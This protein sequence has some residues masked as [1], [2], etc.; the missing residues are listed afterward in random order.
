MLIIYLKKLEKLNEEIKKT[1]Q[2]QNPTNHEGFENHLY[3]ID[4]EKEIAKLLNSVNREEILSYMNLDRNEILDI[5]YGTDI[6]KYTDNIKVDI[7]IIT[8]TQNIG[9]SCKATKLSEVGV[10]EMHGDMFE[11][12]CNIF[13]KNNN[14]K[15]SQ[16]NLNFFKFFDD[17]NCTKKQCEK[18]NL[19]K[20]KD[21]AENIEADWK[22][23]LKFCIQGENT[24][25]KIDYIVFYDK[26]LHYLYLAN[27]DE[28]IGLLD[29]HTRKGS[30]NT[31]MILTRTSNKSSNKEKKVDTR[32]KF[33]M[34]NPIKILK[35]KNLLT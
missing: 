23:I 5:V 14:M 29:T 32:I 18:V 20:C 10:L 28:Y 19:Q 27:I 15:I 24:S 9:I 22:N 7:L 33:K 21:F 1:I 2:K 35:S 17:N 34:I 11:K 4:L 3:G 30:F 26:N 12:K 6:S 16:E 31:R 25:A 8:N 13:A